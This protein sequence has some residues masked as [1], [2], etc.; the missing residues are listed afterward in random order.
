MLVFVGRRWPLQARDVAGVPAVPAPGLVQWLTRVRAALGRGH[1]AMGLPFQVLLE[2]L[3][4]ALEG[5]ALYALVELGVVEQLDRPRD[6]GDLATRA[7]VGAEPLERLLAYLASRGCVRRDRRGRYSANR[8]TKL[9]T[10]EGGWAGWVRFLGAPW[11]VAAYAQIL[12][13]VRDRRD[14]VTVAHGHSF[15]SYLG[16]HPEAAAAF[17]DAQAA[18]AR[19]QALMCADVV[20]LGA[21]R[22]VLDVG[23]GTGTLLSHILATHPE[24][25]GAVLD[26]PHAAPGARATF[27]EAGI[28]E[29]AAF[30]AGNFF[31]AVPTGYDLHILTAV[32][33]DWSDDECARIL[34][35]C[36]SAL[37]VGGRICVIETAL[38]P[39]RYKSFVQASDMLMLAFTRGG[40]ERTPA[41]YR[42]LWSRADLRCVQQR[43]LASTATL[44][45]LRPA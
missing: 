1:D 37:P 12:D 32:I 17:H 7:G 26:L 13:G 43:T 11:T 36:A 22:S 24:L 15:F 21:V 18:G 2:R 44:F 35:N 3:T 39:G 41:Q 42:A 16:N 31:D 30:H 4:G 28:G 9:L 10:D 23:G 27:A 20:P 29:R 25:R 14:P 6:V 45:E 5:P 19:L 34:G 33:H 40:H 8:I 38:D